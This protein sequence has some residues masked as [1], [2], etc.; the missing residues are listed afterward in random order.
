[1]WNLECQIEFQEEDGPYLYLH[2]WDYVSAICSCP[3]LMS[4]KIK[5]QGVYLLRGHPV[6]SNSSTTHQG[7][8][9]DTTG[10]LSD[11]V[12]ITNYL[13]SVKQAEIW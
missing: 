13:Y 2:D 1:M 7:D 5:S 4:A 10:C 9:M 11:I 6:L 8:V 3:I 12:R